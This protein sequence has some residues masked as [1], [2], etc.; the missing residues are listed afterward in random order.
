MKYTLYSIKLAQILD[1][2][3][4][5]LAELKPQGDKKEE[6]I[7]LGDVEVMEEEYRRCLANNVVQNRVMEFLKNP[8]LYLEGKFTNPFTLIKVQ[9]R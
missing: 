6:I 3:K 2:L 5:I 8:R 9:V 7:T 4:R 1:M